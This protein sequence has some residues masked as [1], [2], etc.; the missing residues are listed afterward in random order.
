MFSVIIPVYNGEKFIDNAIKS[1]LNQTYEDFELIVV[2]DGSKDGTQKKLDAYCCN[3]KIHIINQPNG[4]VSNARNNGMQMAKGSHFAFL[5][6]DDEWYENHLEVL[7]SLI[8]KYPDAGLYATFPR[9]N[10]GGG[11]T[12][13]SCKYFDEHEATVY[14]EDF[15]EEYHKD[16]SVKMYVPTSCAVSRAA[17]EKVGGFPP[18]MKIGED[19]EHAL[20]I[21]AYFPVVL[22]K[23]ITAVYEK[24]NS[25]ATKDTSFDPDWT[26]FETVKPIY[27]DTEI[28]VSKRQ[29]IKRIMDWFTIRRCRHY[30]ID[31]NKK[32][33]WKHFC[34]KTDPALR[35]DKFI[36][37]F[38]FLM[39]CKLVRKVFYIRWKKIG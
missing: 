1:V 25:T 5:D 34:E 24:V 29:N 13:D 26:F 22:T 31:G 11:K 21:S 19:L 16:K 39:P 15:F 10:L 12:I 35:K 23:Q 2:N 14:L 36:T 7:A 18:K 28:P 27:E 17:V 6:A 9:I 8:E 30:I 37:F 38:L 32:K 33:A 20:R 4:G 3:E